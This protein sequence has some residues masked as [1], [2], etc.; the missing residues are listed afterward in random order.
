MTTQKIDKDQFIKTAVRILSDKMNFD[1]TQS[2]QVMNIL[3][4]TFSDVDF[5]A[6]EYM[7]STDKCQ[8][9]III[10]NFIGCKKMSG[11]K[12]NSIEQYVISVSTMIRYI[13]KNLVDIDTNDIRR[14][15]LQYEQSVSKVTANN[16][17]RNL[18][19]FFL[20]SK[21]KK[22]L[23]DFILILKLNP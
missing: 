22:D 9:E 6:T 12:D 21:K 19:V 15:I 20:R 10:K 23:R 18:N 5:T 2:N 13:N 8:N 3:T 16:C 7:L 1:N 4:A 11:I 14:F 17:R